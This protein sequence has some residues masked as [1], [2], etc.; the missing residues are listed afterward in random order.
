MYSF[1][2]ISHTADK[3]IRVTADTLSGIFE[4]AMK[5]MA[6]IQKEQAVNRS[7]RDNRSFSISV[8]APDRTALLVD[9]LSEILTLSDIHH[10]VFTRIKFDD[11]SDQHI[12]ATV[13]G[14]RVEDFDEDIKAVTHYLADIVKKGENKLETTIVFDI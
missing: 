12:D 7:P 8:S 10:I 5:G 9:F 2:F 13:F 3:G 1:R 14:S 11:L 4:G 6:A